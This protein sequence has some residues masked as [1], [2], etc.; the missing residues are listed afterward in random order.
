MSSQMEI[1]WDDMQDK[2]TRTLQDLIRFDT[3]NPPGDETPCAEYVRDRLTGEGIEATVLESAPGRG[4]VVA[5]IGGDGS[6]RPLLLMSH[7]DVVPAEFERW[8][9]SPFAAEIH[10]GYLWGRGALDTKCLTAVQLEI[11][12]LLK[13]LR[14]PLKRDVILAATADEE[15]GGTYGMGWLVENHFDLIE[16]EYGINEGGGAGLQIGD[17]RLFLCQTAE[18]GACPIRVRASGKAGH[19]SRPTDDMA[20]AKLVT[21]LDRLVRKRL[22]YHLVSTVEATIRAFSQAMPSPMNE[23]ILGLLDPEQEAQILENMIDVGF[24]TLIKASL[25]NTATPTILRA[26]TKTNVIPSAA[27]AILDCRVLPGQKAD[28]LVGELRAILGDEV[29]IEV[30]RA[31]SGTES[32]YQTPF[33]EIIT[34]VMAEVEPGS[35]VVPYMLPAVTDAPKVAK[36]GIKVYGFFPT[37]SIPGETPGFELTHGHDERISLSLSSENVTLTVQ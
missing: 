27:E 22:P 34:Q 15:A 16:A 24:A 26:G 32:A 20:V 4:N 12:L 10:D 5:R 25:H 11:I 2:V 14:V 7:I 28:D 8:T 23:A 33:F 17:R 31:S 6:E 1:N 36:K 35:L 19:A 18:K 37:K 9:H 29:D 30:M 3:T 21:A 13:R